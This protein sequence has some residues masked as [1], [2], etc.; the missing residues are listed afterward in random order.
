MTP[1]FFFCFDNQA[2]I[3]LKMEESIEISYTSLE[4]EGQIYYNN[5]T[6]EISK[7]LFCSVGF[8]WNII[9]VIEIFIESVVF[10]SKPDGFTV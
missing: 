2:G 10:R 1:V 9:Y 5:L 8:M 7:I 6:I 4:W 3:F